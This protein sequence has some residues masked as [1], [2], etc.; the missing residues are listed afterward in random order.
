MRRCRG[1]R[2]CRSNYCGVV[3]SPDDEA[4]GSCLPIT[5]FSRAGLK[6]CDSSRC[7]CI[8]SN[9]MEKYADQPLHEHTKT[10]VLLPFIFD[11]VVLEYCNGGEIYHELWGE[12]K[13][14]QA[15]TEESLFRICSPANLHSPSNTPAPTTNSPKPE[16]FYAHT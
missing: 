8:G 9:A 11:E 5:G 6:S 14:Q 12:A 10:R 4:T 1:V 3:A 7:S 15:T 13:L 16:S 2:R